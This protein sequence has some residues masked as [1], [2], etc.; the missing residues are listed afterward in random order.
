[1]GLPQRGKTE[2]I[3]NNLGLASEIYCDFNYFLQLSR[4]R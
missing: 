3:T 4:F 2:I 1:M